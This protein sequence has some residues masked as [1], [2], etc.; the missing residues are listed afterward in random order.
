LKREYLLAV[1]CAVAF[2]APAGALSVT[3]TSDAA[4]LTDTLVGEGISVSS[5]VYT[6]PSGAAGIF[7]GGA[8][9]GMEA[10]ILLSTG[11]ASDAEG[12]NSSGAINTTH[13]TPGDLALSALV[14]VPTF[15]AA[16]LEF[17]FATDTGSLFVNFL[18]AS[19]EY[20]EFVGFADI[21]DV[22]GI[23]VDG[24]NIAL[25]GGGIVSVQN[26]NCGESGSGGP[27]CDVFIDNASGLFDVEYDGFSEVLQ[28]QVHGLAPG[29]HTLRFSIAETLNGDVDTVVFLEEGSL[30]G[31]PIPEPGSPV[32]FALG[33][34]LVAF[35]SRSKGPRR[36]AAAPCRRGA[37]RTA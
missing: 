13:G 33:S 36:R 2:S 26:L 22:F 9:I 25:L 15:D 34:L 28:A 35:A 29:G 14:G 23:F 16:S 10:G 11:L 17:D 8:A 4:A 31:A 7:S 1:L 12:P 37:E 24:V 21:D 19:D 6:G 5:P 3:T 18:F 32:L 20:N 30:R 27:N